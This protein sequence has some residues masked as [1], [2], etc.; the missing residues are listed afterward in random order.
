MKVLLVHG[1]WRTPFS[2]LLLNR[3]LRRWG[4]EPELFGYAAVAQRYDSI[5]R[6]LVQRL[7]ALAGQGPYAV[8]GHS[9]GGVFLRSALPLVAGPLPS[10]FIMLGVPNRPP[11]IA[12]ML[13]MRWLYRRLMGDSG[14][15]LASPT[16]YSELPVPAVP[17]TI[18]AG[19]AGPRG[20]WSP[21]GNEL[22]DGL[23]A[24][25]ETLVQDDDR[26]VLL[27]VSH[28]FIMNNVQVQAAIRQALS[29]W[30]SPCSS[31]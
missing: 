1:L 16:F 24:V 13:G 9:L 18:V 19:T 12:G 27:P 30:A 7:E 25:R 17:Y 20:R 14:A 15:N 21:F 26:V 8:I 23:V 10:H 2:F 3:Q 4:D 6:R 28:T 5:L 22:N 31:S 11:R 29:H